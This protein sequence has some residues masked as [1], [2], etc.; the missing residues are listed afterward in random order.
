[1]PEAPSLAGSHGRSG[2]A[3]RAERAALPEFSLAPRDCRWTVLELALLLSDDACV[4]GRVHSACAARGDGCPEPRRRAST[5]QLEAATG[6]TRPDPF[7]VLGQVSCAGPA[8]H[9][10][11]GGPV[12]LDA[13]VGSSASVA[14][15]AS[16]AGTLY[17]AGRHSGHVAGACLS[18]RSVAQPAFVSVP[19]RDR[20]LRPLRQSRQLERSGRRRPSRVLHALVLLTSGSARVGKRRGASPRGACHRLRDGIG[21]PV[22]RAAVLHREGSW[23]DPTSC[24]REESDRP[25][26]RGDRHGGRRGPDLARRHAPPPGITRRLAS[27]T[28]RSR[29]R[30]RLDRRLLRPRGPSAEPSAIRGSFFSEKP[31]TATG[32]PCT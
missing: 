8:G 9:G 6:P 14:R 32:R 20:D 22:G 26:I 10:Q 3:V 4:L 25:A 31:V 11:P 23:P 27:R 2:Y 12:R 15:L 19:D 28:R 1:M 29:R 18:V 7:S 30:H 17:R 21:D 16:S 13:P 24:A 5:G